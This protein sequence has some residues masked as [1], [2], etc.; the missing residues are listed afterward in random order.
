MVILEINAVFLE[1]GTNIP[2]P[3]KYE[4]CMQIWNMSL[5]EAWNTQRGTE[6]VMGQEVWFKPQKEKEWGKIGKTATT[7]T[8]NPSPSFNPKGN[9][10]NND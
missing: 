7:T 4:Q 8:K 3:G 1:Q 6:L 2:T 5:N 9:K 10:W